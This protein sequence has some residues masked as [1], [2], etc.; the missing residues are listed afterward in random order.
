MVAHQLDIVRR[1]I[2]AA[3]LCAGRET[4][5]VT[6][7]AV[8]KS[9]GSNAIRE[10]INAGAVEIGENYLQE[11]L[12]KREELRDLPVSWHFVGHLQS[13]K[14]KYLAGWIQMIHSLDSIGLGQTISREWGKVGAVAEVLIEVNTS[15][16]STKFGIAPDNVRHLLEEVNQLPHVAVRG[17]MTIGPFRPDPEASRPA[18][19]LLRELRDE[20]RTEACP[21]NHLSMGMTND[22]EV[23]IEEGST[24]VRIGTAIFGER[25]RRIL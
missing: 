16:E 15:G 22:F 13:N 5:E 19:R 18:F 6:L 17:L 20:L 21:L 12:P 25:S 10:A 7:V 23:A 4:G 11:L 9:F 8:G 3:C 1:R 24:I 2:D 14:A